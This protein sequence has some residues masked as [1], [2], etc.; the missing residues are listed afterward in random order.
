MDDRYRR[1]RRGRRRRVRLRRRR[2]RWARPRRECRRLRNTSRSTRASTPT[3][4][5]RRTRVPR[6]RARMRVRTRRRRVE[7]NE[8][9]QHGVT[10]SL[11]ARVR[12]REGAPHA[13]GATTP[14]VILAVRV[15]QCHVR[16]VRESTSRVD[17]LRPVREILAHRS[18]VAA[19]DAFT[20]ERE[21][22]SRRRVRRA[23][24]RRRP[25]L[26]RHAS[27]DVSHH[28][29]SKRA[30][31]LFPERAHEKSR[32]PRPRTGRTAARVSTRQVAIFLTERP[33][34]RERRQRR[35][36]RAS[37]GANDP[38]VANAK[39]RTRCA[40]ARVAESFGDELGDDET[41]GSLVSHVCARLRT[42]DA[43]ETRATRETTR[44]DAPSRT[45]RPFAP[46]ARCP[47]APREGI[48]ATP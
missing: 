42:R 12:P 15:K 21:R 4:R 35:V 13:G 24:A 20:R 9:T 33:R 22:G 3:R 8:R 32:P 1:R 38:G 6:S 43:R 16:R 5:T 44:R 36:Q 30:H 7:T 25:V 28:A 48:R 2:V 29:S 31:D 47:A 17:H 41:T 23:R 34:P 14:L 19:L 18:S 45:Y 37:D 46:R 27:L 11:F 10:R 26:E 40:R 39:S